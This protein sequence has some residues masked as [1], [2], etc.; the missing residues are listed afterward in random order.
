MSWQGHASDGTDVAINIPADAIHAFATAA[1]IGGLVGLLVLLVTP[2]QAYLAPGDRVRLLAGAVVRFSALAIAS[3]TAPGDHRHLPC[4][5]RAEQPVA[6]ERRPA[7]G[8]R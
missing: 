1:W 7:T 8:A 6:A 2:A 5:G 4:A 3:V